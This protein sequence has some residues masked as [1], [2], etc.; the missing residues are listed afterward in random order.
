LA[1]QTEKREFA[2]KLVAKKNSQLPERLMLLDAG[3]PSGWKPR[4]FCDTATGEDTD[5][6]HHDHH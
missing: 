3:R 1:V 4:G 6:H 2:R 5:V